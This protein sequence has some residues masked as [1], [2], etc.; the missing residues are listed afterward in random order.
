[1]CEKGVIGQG[2]LPSIRIRMFGEFAV[3][4]LISSST[5]TVSRYIP[6]AWE[7]LNRRKAPLL[8]LKILLCAPG[9]RA[10][11]EEIMQ[12]LWPDRAI[13][14]MQHAF[15][16]VISLLRRRIL[17]TGTGESLL[18]TIRAEGEA[19]SLKLSG[20]SK[21][22]VDADALLELGM[23]AGRE[24][25]TGK[26]P[27]S[28]LEQAHRLVQGRFLEDHSSSTWSRARRSTI[29]GGVHRILYQLFERYIYDRQL[30][31][32]EAL[33]LSFLEEHPTDQ[34]ALYHLM[35]L[36]A[37]RRRGQEA[38]EIYLY[39]VDELLIEGKEPAPYIRRL[40]EQLNAGTLLREVSGRYI[41]VTTDMHYPICVA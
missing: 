40:G 18:Q 30:D 16:T 14:S 17:C 19:V 32:A 13:A 1:M 26:D 11:R 39:A 23:R 9:R 7:E 33:L 10:S 12:I 24:I 21:L 29:N 5:S 8:V 31:Q 27:L 2:T 22:W 15:E 4:R 6:L 41:A 36:L 38:Y 20:Q 34:D 28:T 35:E 25:R 3:E 37:D